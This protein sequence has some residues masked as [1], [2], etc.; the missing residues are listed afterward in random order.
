MAKKTKLSTPDLVAIIRERAE[1]Y[2]ESL[3]ASIKDPEHVIKFLEA[4]LFNPDK[5]EFGVV[6]LDS[7][8]H[9]T[10]FKKLFEG[11]I[12]QSVVYPREVARA[13]INA[14]A[15]AAII[16]HN[17]P[18][19]SSTPSADDIKITNELKAALGTLDIRLLDHF[20][21][22]SPEHTTSMQK[23]GMF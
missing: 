17:H 14:N 12:N 21:I 5:E 18:G 20:I 11:T 8:H 9:I 6:F 1:E 7:R 4:A 13:C 19:G 23:L 3:G 15:S 16:A 2:F 22:S 10:G